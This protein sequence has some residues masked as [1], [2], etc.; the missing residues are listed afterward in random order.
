MNTSTNLFSATIKK[1]ILTVNQTVDGQLRTICLLELDGTVNLLLDGQTV[2][3]KTQHGQFS[4]TAPADSDG[5]ELLTSIATALTQRALRKSRNLFLGCFA[6]FAFAATAFAFAYIS[7]ANH[8]ESPAGSDAAAKLSPLQGMNREIVP[9][10]IPSPPPPPVAPSV[11]NNNSSPDGW[12]LPESVRLGLPEKLRKAADRKLFTVEYSA[13]HARTLYVFA[14]PECP[15]CQRLEPALNAAA[16]DFN[17]VIFPVAVIGRAKSIAA[18]TPVLCLPPEQREAAWK[19]LFE[20]GHDVL[21]MGN[22]I[23]TTPADEEPSEPKNGNCDIANK[24][25]GVNEMAYQTYRIPG[26][27]WVIADDGRH[28]SQEVLQDPLKLQVFMSESEVAHAAK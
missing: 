20:V 24:A 13:T 15:N 9:G 17:V 21:N 27:P 8:F 25:L 23:A 6:I 11:D 16:A 22:A 28:V 4:L 12:V 7:H 14:D 10:I 2:L 18:I 5:S 3:C 1:D 26:T 19:H